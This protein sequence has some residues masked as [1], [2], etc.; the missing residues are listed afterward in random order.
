MNV[1]VNVAAN[2]SNSSD[3]GLFFYDGG[4]RSHAGATLTGSGIDAWQEI[5]AIASS[6]AIDINFWPNAYGNFVD[7]WLMGDIYRT[8]VDSSVTMG[9][10]AASSAVIAGQGTIGPY[11]CFGSTI[12]DTVLGKNACAEDFFN[13][14][15][16]SNDAQYDISEVYDFSVSGARNIA[17]HPQQTPEGSRP[18]PLP[19]GPA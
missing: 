15:I 10:I 12:H 7:N 13:D 16:G 8:A 11:W 4:T 14:D 19:G 5:G 1:A 3:A 18:R 9:V 2:S 6:G 17:T